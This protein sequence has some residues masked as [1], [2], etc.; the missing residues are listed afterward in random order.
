MVI[1]LPSQLRYVT[2]LVIFIEFLAIFDFVVYLFVFLLMNEIHSLFLHT[3]FVDYLFTK[4]SLSLLLNYY[5]VS[6]HALLYFHLDLL[7]L[8]PFV[9]SC[10]ITVPSGDYFS[11]IKKH[12]LFIFKERIKE[13]E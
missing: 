4:V 13:E 12:R 3:I 2:P 11:L 10:S 9:F 7:T 8:M 1:L 5:T 6:L